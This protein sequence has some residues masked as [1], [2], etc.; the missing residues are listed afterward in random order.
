MGQG[1]SA[2]GGTASECGDVA[3]A[4]RA[5]ASRSNR[6]MGLWDDRDGFFYDAIRVTKDE[7]VEEAAKA[8]AKQLDAQVERA[9]AAA[10]AAGATV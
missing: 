4:R 5:G 8:E 1:A 3:G 7:L 2:G 9:V 6:Q 10:A